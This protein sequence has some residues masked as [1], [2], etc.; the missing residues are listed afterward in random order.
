[1]FP[2]QENFQTDSKSAPGYKIL[3]NLIFTGWQDIHVLSKPGYTT[4]MHT[5]FK[6]ADL[7][8]P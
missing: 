1:M 4:Q 6:G 7:T 3:N 5:L 2:L 8:W